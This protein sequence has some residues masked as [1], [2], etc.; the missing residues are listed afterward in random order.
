[1][2]MMMQDRILFHNG[3]EYSV[4]K[5]A[6]NLAPFFL[7]VAGFFFLLQFFFRTWVPYRWL[8]SPAT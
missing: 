8:S 5:A 2:M 3:C 6:N 1:M 4:N 7:S